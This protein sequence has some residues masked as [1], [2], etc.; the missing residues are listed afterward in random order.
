MIEF[1]EAQT[2][3]VVCSPEHLKPE[4]LKALGVLRFEAGKRYRA[5]VEEIKEA[6]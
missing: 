3:W 5:T 6:A 4:H 2:E 1:D